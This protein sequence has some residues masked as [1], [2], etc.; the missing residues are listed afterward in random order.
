MI[1]GMA[2]LRYGCRVSIFLV[3]QGV[4]KDFGDHEGTY[5]RIVGINVPHFLGEKVDII[6]TTRFEAIGGNNGMD[7]R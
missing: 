5:C 4:S 2:S 1:V 6:R 7:G 3:C